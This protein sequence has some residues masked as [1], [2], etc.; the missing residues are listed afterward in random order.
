[1][2][3]PRTPTLRQW[4][5]TDCRLDRLSSD[6]RWQDD[7]AWVD[8]PPPEMTERARQLGVAMIVAWLLLGAILLVWGLTG[9]VH[10][11]N[12]PQVPSD[13]PTVTT[14]HR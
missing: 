4:S 1:M 13:L 9:H 12:D 11:T 8:E 7:P 6:P 3:E 10:I 14:V 5:D 2:S